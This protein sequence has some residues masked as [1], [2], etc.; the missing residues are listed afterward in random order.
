VVSFSFYL[1][2]QPFLEVFKSYSGALATRWGVPVASPLGVFVVSLFLLYPLIL[3]ISWA[4][5]RWVEKPFIRLGQ[6]LWSRWA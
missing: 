5:Y 6:R 1:I 4:L 3:L 2:H